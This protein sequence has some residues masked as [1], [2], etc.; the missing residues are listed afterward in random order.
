MDTFTVD[1]NNERGYRDRNEGKEEVEFIE[2]ITVESKKYD[3]KP[4]SINLKG[5]VCSVPEIIDYSTLE[6]E[7]VGRDGT[8]YYSKTLLPKEVG[9]Y[10]LNV[11]ISTK[12]RYYYGVSS[13]DFDISR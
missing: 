4:V 6:F 1:K 9:S 3:G 2:G 8:D 5:F 12:N 11:S 7:V 13:I 10:T